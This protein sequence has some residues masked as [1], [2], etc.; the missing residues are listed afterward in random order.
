MRRMGAAG[1]T[2]AELAIS[3]GLLGVVLSAIVGTVVSMQRG[4]V[5]QREVARAEDA[6][7]VAETTIATMVRTAGANPRNI[8]GANAPRLVPDPVTPG[9]FNSLRVVSDFNPADSS[10]A[11]LLEDA[12]VQTRNDTLFV[13][14]QAGDSSRAVAY[15]VRSMLFQYYKM[16]TLLTTAAAVA[17]AQ[18][19]KV[20]LVAPRHARTSALARRETWIYLRNRW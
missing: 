3:L 13:R 7:R 5:R 11:G 9:T 6:L 14:W 8:T 1:F 19:V 17:R 16:D 12:L 15:P 2:L 4:Y 18:R 20:T 10:V